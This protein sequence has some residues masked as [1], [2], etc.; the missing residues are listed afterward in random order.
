LTSRKVVT[1]KDGDFKVKTIK[2]KVIEKISYNNLVEMN[3]KLLTIKKDNKERIL[4]F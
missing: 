4:Y 2:P 3:L 1:I